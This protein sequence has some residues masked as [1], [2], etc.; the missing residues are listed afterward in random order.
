MT[1]RLP[2]VLSRDEAAL[3]IQQPNPKAVTGIRNRAMLA[4]MLHTGLRVSEVTKMRALDVRWPDTARMAAVE[5][6]GGK[7]GKD[8]TVPLHP[9]TVE[10][11]KAWADARP[12]AEHFFCTV[13]ERGGIASGGGQGKPLSPRYVQLMVGRYALRAGIERRVT[14]HSLRHTCATDMLEDGLD[15]RQVP[16]GARPRQPRHHDDLHARPAREPRR[17]DHRPVGSCVGRLRRAERRQS[18][19]PAGAETED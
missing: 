2:E 6:R 3:L 17:G 16:G 9:A 7:G 4:L 11:L 13:W 5:V 12:D 18:A 1:K 19:T 15:V 10:L 8:R 14:P